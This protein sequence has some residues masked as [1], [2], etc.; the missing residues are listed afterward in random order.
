MEIAN[1]KI[2]NEE[3]LHLRKA[4]QV[5]LCAQKFESKILLCHQCKQADTCSILQVLSLGAGHHAD[6]TVIA[7]GPDEKEA[8][9]GIIE[10]FSDGAGI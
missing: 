2:Q 6:L 9:I 3:G 5:V 10:V 8:V 4:A 1:I 7:T